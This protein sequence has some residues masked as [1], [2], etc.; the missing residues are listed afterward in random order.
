MPGGMSIAKMLK[1]TTA[2]T[3]HIRSIF[4]LDTFIKQISKTVCNLPVNI[5]PMMIMDLFL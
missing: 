1:D 5:M 2:A 3:R 4:A